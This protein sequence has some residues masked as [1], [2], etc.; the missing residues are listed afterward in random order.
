MAGESTVCD[1]ATSRADGKEYFDVMYLFV[2]LLSL[3]F[4]YLKVVICSNPSHFVTL[5]VVVSLTM[6]LPAS[7]L[8][9][10]SFVFLS[11]AFVFFVL[12]FFC[13]RISVFCLSSFCIK[14]LCSTWGLLSPQENYN[15]TAVSVLALINVR[16]RSSRGHRASWSPKPAATRGETPGGTELSW[17]TR[18]EYRGKVVTDPR[19]HEVLIL[20]GERT[21]VLS[22]V[23]L[24]HARAHDVDLICKRALCSLKMTSN[25]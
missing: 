13:L 16:G 18:V 22:A 20:I 7:P 12:L 19:V 3:I 8:L 10:G 15:I 25:C 4:V 6:P 17:N 1:M 24:R 2:L 21:S 9:H 11:L 23:W 5:T 14:G